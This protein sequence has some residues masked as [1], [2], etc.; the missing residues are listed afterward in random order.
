VAAAAAAAAAGP[1]RPAA[2][3]EHVARF[4][5]EYAAAFSEEAVAR[6][7][8]AAAD[9][10]ADQPAAV[11]IEEAP[12]GDVDVTIVAFDY[13]A[14]FSLIAGILSGTGFNVLSGHVF[15]AA[16]GAR[17]YIV[18]QF[19]G[20]LSGGV[21]VAEW[22]EDVT[23]RLRE[24]IGLLE[25]GGHDAVLRARHMVNELV[26]AR[27]S[28]L[29]ADDAPVLYPV[30]IQVDNTAG[31]FTR[32]MVVSQ[33]TPAFLYA[34]SNALALRGITIERVRIRTVQGRAEDEIDVLDAAGQP[35]VGRDEEDR[36]RFSVLL[37]KQFTYFLGRAPDPFAAL[38]RFEQLCTQTADVSEKASWMA[39]FS[40]PEACRV[41]A[42]VLG[43]SDFIWEDF[44]RTQYE[45]LL[46]MLGAEA[47]RARRAFSREALAD[48][49]E[50]AM[51]DA[52]GFEARKRALNRWKDEESFLIDLD[53]I[54]HAGRD[55]SALAEPLTRVAELTV[56]GALDIVFEHLAQQHG[57]PRTVGGLPARVAVCGLGKMGG[58]ALGYA[59]DIE[60]LVVYSDNGR[61]DGAEPVD[62]SEFFARL[63]EETARFIVSRREGVFHVDLRL[64]PYGNSGPKACSLEA[65]C[66]YYGPGGDAQSY[67]RL[68]LTRLRAV[69]GDAELGSQLERLRNAFVY[70]ASWLNIEQLRT[71]R[72]KQ[73][74]AKVRDA[75]YNAKFSPGALVDL[76]YFV[77]VLQVRHGTTVLELRTPRLHEALEGMSAHGIV[78]PDMVR[79]LT[80]AYYFLR[81]LINGLRML[82][83]NARDLFLPSADSHEYV[84]LARRMGYERGQALNPEQQLLVDFEM[85]TARVRAFIEKHFGRE[86]LPD[87]AAGNVADLLLSENPDEALRR[88][89]LGRAGFAHV[90]RAYRNLRGLAGDGER[91][92]GF[93]RLAILAVD[94]LR[95][96]PD[97]DMALNNWERFVGELPSAAAH[98][99]EL[100][101]QPRRLDILLQLFARSQFLA[102]TLVRNSNFF[103]WVSDPAVLHATRDAVRLGMDLERF[104][105]GA[106]GEAWLNALRRYRRREFVRIGARDMCLRLPL[107]RITA[108]LS[109]LADALVGAVLEREWRVMR[110]EGALDADVRME[111]YFCVMAL[112]KLGGRELN[113]S[114][115]IDL[116]AMYDDA[117]LAWLPHEEAR[118]IYAR[119]MERV[120]AA[121]TAHMETGYL[122]RVDLRLRPHGVSGGL[123]QPVSALVRYYG[124]DAHLW[125]IQALLKARPVAGGLDAGYRFLDQVR[126]AL[127]RRRDPAEI[128]ASIRGM[129]DKALEQAGTA[130]ETNVKVGLG[131]IRD[132]E[133]LVQGLQLM[134]AHDHPELL[135]GHT[136]KAL[137]T[138]AAV[139]LLPDAAVQTLREGYALLRRVEHYLQILEDRQIHA[140]P[141][142]RQA[143][144]ALARRVLGQEQT[145]DGFL[146]T[147]ENTQQKIRALFEQ[148]IPL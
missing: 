123:V 41:L 71:L 1:E 86:S 144:A 126:P 75:R 24:T 94:M 81:H 13:P 3:A 127:L 104:C 70:E 33:D 27:L 148:H 109:A 69:A 113:Y 39:L 22:R 53:H 110:E 97:P 55:V 143:L 139:G 138:I 87:A 17:R 66:G 8:R 128:A 85:H 43:T 26:A 52:A 36:L 80:S 18:D 20:E 61:T 56:A 64:R 16:P 67:E 137:D 72:E 5:G 103:E 92:E 106:Q 84:H 132:V 68:A 121:L 124:H 38:S 44:V 122:Y 115:D 117:V 99:R 35:I 62:N 7:A 57:R 28:E 10:N 88:S 59:S 11:M 77:Q 63:A 83:G 42:K 14:E 105:R 142:D 114:S 146:Q 93:V 98:Y 50:A 100:L 25:T 74:A 116:V 125:E 119:L 112:G 23:R 9:L 111:P 129:R 133:F 130:R 54:V 30:D 2:V 136:L 89:V 147:I 134:H 91:R 78:A 82:R 79:D 120:R 12:G 118:A 60:L 48:R 31:P 90:E 29:R 140:I 141:Q 101:A 107:S 19:T 73:F 4:G 34:L 96:G 102:D 49:L 95:R 47:G 32:L 6:H 58:I 51:K 37:T 21:N 76:E 45:T 135:G 145:A 46:P 108:D 131:G 65:F 40:D 15:T